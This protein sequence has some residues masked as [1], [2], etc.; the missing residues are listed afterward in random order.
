MPTTGS[1]QVYGTNVV[2]ITT[3]SVNPPIKMVTAECRWRAFNRNVFTNSLTV[4][5][6]PDQ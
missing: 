6:S 3:V 4:Y 2:T 5:R 1:N